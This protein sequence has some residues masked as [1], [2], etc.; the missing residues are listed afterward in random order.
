MKLFPGCFSC[1]PIYIWGINLTNE[2]CFGPEPII[3]TFIYKIGSIRIIFFEE[4]NHR[5]ELILFYQ[6][7]FQN[8]TLHYVFTRIRCTDHDCIAYVIRLADRQ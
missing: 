6:I 3:G 8:A 1:S 7:E 2:Q 5:I 4:F